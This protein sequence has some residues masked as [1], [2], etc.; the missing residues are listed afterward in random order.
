MLFINFTRGN[1]LIH[2][3]VI[4]KKHLSKYSSRKPFSSENVSDFTFSLY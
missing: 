3:K 4:T 1:I 2:L